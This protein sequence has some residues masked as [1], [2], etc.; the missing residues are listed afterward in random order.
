[1]FTRLINEVSDINQQYTFL[2]LT[3]EAITLVDQ[4]CHEIFKGSQVC[5]QNH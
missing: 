1:M 5:D 4:N 3:R 2:F